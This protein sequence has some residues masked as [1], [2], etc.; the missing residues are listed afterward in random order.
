M[1]QIVGHAFR[2]HR[3]LTGGA[4]A[5]QLRNNLIRLRFFRRRWFVAK[6]AMTDFAAGVCD[7]AAGA[8]RDCAE[9]YHHDHEWNEKIL[10]IL[11][12]RRWLRHSMLR[13]RK[14]AK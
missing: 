9:Q 13:P 6:F 5:L 14:R 8:Q 11:S 4:P 1:R 3:K 7:V 2:L 12:A 10:A